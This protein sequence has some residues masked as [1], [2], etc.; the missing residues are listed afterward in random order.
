MSKRTGMMTVK[1]LEK[2]GMMT[3]GIA[4]KTDGMTGAD[5]DVGA[6]LHIPHFGDCP[7]GRGLFGYTHILTIDADT[8]GTAVFTMWER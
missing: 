7:A 6:H 8:P 4:E 2:T 3:E 1:I 5:G